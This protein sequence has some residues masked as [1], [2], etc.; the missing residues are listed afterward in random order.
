[1]AYFSPE[2]RFSPTL[3]LTAEHLA[4]RR[5]R[6]SFVHALTVSGGGTFQAGFEAAPIGRVAYEHRWRLGR[7]VDLS[8]GLLLAS[9]VFDG[10]REEEYGGFTQL[11]VRF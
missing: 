5:Y 6:L 10:D 7:R 11:S 4:W 3:D 2:W 9:R 8:Y 1:M